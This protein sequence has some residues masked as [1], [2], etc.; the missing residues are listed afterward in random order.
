V[1]FTFCCWPD[2]N[3]HGMCQNENSGHNEDLSVWTKHHPGKL[4]SVYTYL[5]CI[6]H[7]LGAEEM[8]QWLRVLAVLTEEPSLVPTPY[9]AAHNSSCKI[10]GLPLRSLGTVYGIHI[11]TQA[12]KEKRQLYTY[13]IKKNLLHTSQLPGWRHLNEEITPLSDFKMASATPAPPPPPHHVPKSFPH[14][15]KALPCGESEAGAL[16]DALVT[17]LPQCL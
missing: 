13:K 6:K 15:L 16:H 12:K 4:Y 14:T 17:V 8:A 9:R 3:L 1:E 10:Q 7:T 5:I 11:C 2:P